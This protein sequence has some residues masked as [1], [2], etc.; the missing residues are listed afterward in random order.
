MA[1]CTLSAKLRKL[2]AAGS[3]GA[4]WAHRMH[5]DALAAAPPGNTNARNVSIRIH[6]NDDTVKLVEY[7]AGTAGRLHYT[8]L[9]LHDCCQTRL[10]CEDSHATL[11]EALTSSDIG[12]IWDGGACG[13]ACSVISP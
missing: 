3:R 6:F 4:S 12:D 2:S 7:P 9:R 1:L 10:T 5:G 13:G 11:M 8:R